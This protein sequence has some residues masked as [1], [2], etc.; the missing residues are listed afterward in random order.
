MKIFTIKFFK[1]I[2]IKKIITN[3][4]I[5]FI[6]DMFPTLTGFE[7]DLNNPVINRSVS[8]IIFK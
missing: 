4:L 7:K 6:E 1:K 2:N 3:I 5:L 8:L